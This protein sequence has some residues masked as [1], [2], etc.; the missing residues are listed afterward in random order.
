MNGRRVL[1]F[2]KDLLPIS[3]TF[4]PAQVRGYRRWAPTLAGFQRVPGINPASLDAAVLFDAGRPSERVLLKRDQFLPYLGIAGFRVLR[5]LERLRP[6]IVHAH[7]GY[8]AVLIADAARRCGIP[9]VVTLHG[10]DILR[11]WQGWASGDEG[12]FFRF[13]PAKM[14]RLFTD[15][16]TH[17]IAVS[18]ALRRAAIKQGAPAD[19]LHLAYT[20][21]A[22][23]DFAAVQHGPDRTPTVLFVGRL[24]GFKGCEVLVR[25]MA[26]V[27]AV[28]PGVQAVVAGDGPLR[29]ELEKLASNLK[30]NVRFAGRVDQGEVRRLL[31]EATVFCLP[32]LTEPDG[33]FEAFGMVMLEAQAAGVPV[34]TSAKAGPEAVIDGK[35]GLLF[36]ER[37][38][39]GLAR[40]LIELCTDPSRCAAMGEAGRMHVA[41]RYDVRRCSEAIEAIYDRIVAPE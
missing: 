26:Q 17:F 38:V 10:T 1:V 3:E 35:T 12:F 18:D 15:E 22:L 2:R 13:Y 33:V 41:D 36:A 20:G 23:D 40:Q 27:Q 5:L 14:R 7:F 19:R 25:A 11:D 34:V 4:I 6:D 8:D 32:S 37:D 30:A 28:V 24:V 9:L 16:Q 31:G 29:G 21:V 39:D